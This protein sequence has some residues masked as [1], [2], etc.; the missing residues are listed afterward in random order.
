[1]KIGILTYFWAENPGTFLQAYSTYNAVRDAFPTADVE[2]INVK[3]RKIYFKVAK[4][5]WFSP[6]LIFKAYKRYNSYQNA[7]KGVKFSSGTYIG[8]NTKQAFN[9]INEQKYDVIFV[10]SDTI[11][12]LYQWNLETERLPVYYLEGIQAKKIMLAASCGSTSIND[13]PDNMKKTAYQCLNEFNRLGVRDQNTLDLVSQLK[14]NDNNIEII[15]DPTFTYEI[16]T[17]KAMKVLKR[18]NFDFQTPSIV[19][20]LPKD[21]PLL[22]DTVIYFKNMGWNIVTFEYQKY[23]DYCLFV[24]PNEWAGIP[25]FVNLVITDRFHGSIF[26]IKNNTPVVAVDCQKNRI[27]KESS[28]KLKCLF[29]EFG[30]IDNYVNFIENPSADHYFKIID[31]VKNSSIN[32]DD[33]CQLKRIIYEKFLNKVINELNY[34]SNFN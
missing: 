7:Y 2:L 19:L 30:M 11:L 10:G 9:Y 16:D 14:G 17:G 4:K 18:Y 26:S 1:M 13:F 3:S 33:V 28:S 20:N 32:Y 15:P 27:S 23:A 22:A 34:V 8:K 21:F 5:Y 6:Q 29:E 24:E 25:R 31:T 12:M